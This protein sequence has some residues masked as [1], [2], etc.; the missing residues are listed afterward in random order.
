MRYSDYFFNWL[1][2]DLFDFLEELRMFDIFLEIIKESF[3]DI[4][5]ST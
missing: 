3:N 5:P 4:D 1:T 2:F